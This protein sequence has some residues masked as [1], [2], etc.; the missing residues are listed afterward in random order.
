MLDVALIASSDGDLYEIVQTQLLS[1][2]DGQALCHS[3]L[4][5]ART[6]VDVKRMLTEHKPDILFVDAMLA[7]DGDS[8]LDEP[9]RA[10][11]ELLVHLRK[12]GAS[13]PSV[14]LL[15]HPIEEVEGFCAAS[16]RD[17]PLFLK[18]LSRSNL[19]IALEKLGLKAPDQ[20]PHDI[21]VE[22]DIDARLSKVR[23][24]DDA[25]KQLHEKEDFV[26]DPSSLRGY[27]Q[28]FRNWKMFRVVEEGDRRE[29]RPIYGWRDYLAAVGYTI[30]DKLIVGGLGDAYLSDLQ[31]RPEGLNRLHFRFHVADDL[32]AVP[33][34]A[35]YDF[36]TNKF[37]RI[38]SPV[39]RRLK[40]R[41]VRPENEKP[42]DMHNGA[43]RI[44]FVLAQVEGSLRLADEH[45]ETVAESHWFEPL[46]N[47]ANERDYFASLRQR[48]RWLHGD[49]Q[50]DLFTG[51]G[52]GEAFHTA[53]EERL[54][55][56][57][58]SFVHFAG[59]SYCTADGRTF[60][61]LPGEEED[62]LVG[63]S[64]G[65]FARWVGK[66]GARFVYLSSCR[67]SSSDSVRELVEHGI[68]HVLGFRWE[69]EDDQAASFASH[70][71]GELLDRDQ[72]FAK[73][74]RNACVNLHDRP[75]STS[76]IWVS[77]LL[78][79]QTAKW[80]QTMA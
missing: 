66:A 22:L 32:F 76:P 77:P 53:L 16:R 30:Y 13:V 36:N 50:V 49:L 38:Y 33:F 27:A 47:L 14:V 57:R 41:G 26:R 48:A 29:S 45:G 6:C 51:G 46:A 63:L 68:P 21:T 42:S 70:F 40:Y 31:A 62:R 78:I 73:A 19:E 17:T 43:L 69:V 71:Y 24:F 67:G 15:A 5:R 4:P 9:G 54:R 39:A 25:G 18:Y 34:E 75:G 3:V 23:V 20:T 56:N 1:K 74:Y 60:L 72:S 7:F 44:L 8:T 28:T 59:H 65:A 10:T 35:L 12:Q 37:L 52:P 11:V 2:Q 79:M 64:I 61:V 58:Y 55:T 80:W